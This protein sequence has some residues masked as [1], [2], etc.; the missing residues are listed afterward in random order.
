MLTDAYGGI[1]GCD[2]NSD[3]LTDAY[4]GVDEWVFKI[5][6]AYKRLWWSEWVAGTETSKRLLMH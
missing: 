1:G 3:L 5:L 2:Q 6:N 4:G